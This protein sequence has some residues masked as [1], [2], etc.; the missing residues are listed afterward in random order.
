MGKATTI[1]DLKRLMKKPKNI[2]N[3]CTSAHIHH[4]KC[5]AGD[6][7]LILANGSI[8][9]AKELYETALSLG[10]KFEE[11]EE[12]TIYD[13]SQNPLYIFSLNKE[14]GN[15]ENK[16]I[17][18][19]WK[20][21]GGK[22]I[23][24]KLRNGFGI[25]TTPEHKYLTFEHMQFVE[26]TAAELKLGDNVVCARNLEFFWKEKNSLSIEYESIQV[27]VRSNNQIL[28]QNIRNHHEDLAF[29]PVESISQSYEETV[30]DFT[31][32]DNHNFVAE[33][34]IIHNTALTD[35]LLAAAGLMS[36]KAA[37][38]LEEGMAT[39]QH[40]DEQE[41]LLT[42]DAANVSMSHDYEGQ[43]YLI[44]LIDTPG[45]VDFGGN[46]TRA[47]R[48]IDG[49][50]VLICG[51]EGIMPQTETVVRQAIRER[52]KPVL[53]INK[54]DRMVNELKL[55]PEQIQERFMKLIV[56]FNKLVEQVAEEEFK[57]AWKVNIMDGS[58][59][60]GS[61]R[62]NWGLS[63]PFMKKKG[64]TFKQIIEQY[65]TNK[66]KEEIS[67][68]F[69]KNAALF[70]VILDMVIRHLPNPLQAQKYRIPHIWK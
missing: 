56:D 59:A 38:N 31:I 67:E 4:G 33:G 64:I 5:I 16:K 3:I 53:F 8:K 43:S 12:H 26:K 7:R 1:E 47:M 37:G 22:T 10:T 28:L 62:E 66:T 68:W 34:M 60:F 6:S 45:H 30:Y 40:K 25:T 41:R 50:I 70:E 46:V 23:T 69:C 58:V 35:N 48:A 19:A 52:V 44:N 42:V 27:Q 24:V 11:K 14:T 17:D 20:L 39:W 51:V 15:L 29:V 9:T 54:V 18:L 2:R 57:E 65:T 55:T 13:L 49:T 36:E 61:A 32:P 63:L 21:Q